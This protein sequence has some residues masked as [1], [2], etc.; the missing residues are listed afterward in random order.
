MFCCFPKKFSKSARGGGIHVTMKLC[1]SRGCEKIM[2][3]NKIRRVY[4]FV[5]QI[6]SEPNR[7]SFSH[8][9]KFLPN[10]LA[11]KYP[12]WNR[13]KVTHVQQLLPVDVPVR[14]LIALKFLVSIEAVA[15]SKN[16]AW[17][18]KILWTDEAYFHLQVYVNTCSCR[19]WAL[20]NPPAHEQNT[21]PC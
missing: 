4:Q 10:L 21:S 19:I 14:V 20:E 6:A 2:T 16:N 18:W 5:N 9:I 1:Q 8:R 11:R 12:N 13:Y 7:N 17:T 3:E 15:H